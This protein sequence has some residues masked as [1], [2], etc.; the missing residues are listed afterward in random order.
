MV[1]RNNR[2]AIRHAEVGQ[3]IST[4]GTAC[5]YAR[6]GIAAAPEDR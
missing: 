4:A 2:R 3:R 5:A 6:E 1:R